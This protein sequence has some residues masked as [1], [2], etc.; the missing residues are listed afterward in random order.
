MV[1][2]APPQADLREQKIHRQTASKVAAQLLSYLPENERTMATLLVLSER[3][4]AYYDN[5]LPNAETLDDLMN[6]AMPQSMDEPPP[7]TDDDIPF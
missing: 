5:G 2:Q 3:L 4:V 6:R 1:A 7:H